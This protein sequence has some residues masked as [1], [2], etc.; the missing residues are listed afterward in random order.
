MGEHRFY[1]L[2]C[3]K[4]SD[5]DR[6]KG[7]IGHY[8]LSSMLHHDSEKEVIEHIKKKHPRE[9]KKAVLDEKTETEVTT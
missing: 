7:L 1:C 2:I 8:L 6:K 9:Y 3:K 4:L 5:K